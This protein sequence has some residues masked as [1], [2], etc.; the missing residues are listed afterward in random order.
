[1]TPEDCGKSH[2]RPA[3][4]PS[5]ESTLSQ[6][7]AGVQMDLAG[8]TVSH[9]QVLEK[10]GAGGMGV[11]YKARDT[12]LDRIVALKFLPPHLR[13]NEDLKQRLTEEARAASALDHPNIVVIH[14][15]GETAAGD[16]F[17]AMT[18]HEGVTLRERIGDKTAARLTT[19]GALEIA[20]Q[21]ASGLA[22]AHQRGIFHR[23]IKPT[24][25][26]LAKD[27]V[28]RII[29]FGL[30]KSSEATVTMDGSTKGTP[31]YMSPEQASGGAVDSRTDLWSLGAV[32]YEMLAGRPAFPGDMHLQVMHSIVNAPAPRL[33]EVRPDLP[34]SIDLVVARAL[35]K[36]VAKRYP[37][38][39]DMARDL[40]AALASLDP[41]ARKP[42]LLRA[43]YAIPALA[44]VVLLAGAA[45]WLYQRSENRHWAREQIPEIAKL[46]ADHKPVAAFLLAQKAQKYLP[47]DAELSRIADGLTHV[48]S[49]RSSPPGA[50]V[51]I[52]DYL[53]PGDAWFALGSTPLENIKLPSGYLRWRVSK[54]G[55][56]EHN[57]APITEDIHG[58]RKEF[59]FPLEAIAS[60]PPGMVPVPAVDFVDLLWGL[61]LVGPYKLPA[62]YID[63]YE[64]TNRQYQEFVDQGGYQK[65]DYWKEKFLRDG[66]ELS[67]EQAMDLFR[68][69]SGRPGPSTWEAGHF[70]AGHADD[71]VGGVSWYEASAYAEF[72]GKS[73]PVIAQ[74]FRAAP[75]SVAKYIVPQ[76][77]FLLSAVAPGGKYQGLGPWGTYDMGG[78][79]AEWCRNEGGGQFRYILGGGWN[80]SSV[81]YF[82]PGVLPPLNRS[83]NSGFRCVRNTTAL[84]AEA[85]AEIRLQVRDFSKAKP[86]SDEVFRIYKTMWDPL[87]ST[88]R[89]ASL[90]IL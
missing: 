89:H 85:T 11:V 69:A 80:T 79:V 73:L 70:P 14:E 22:Q 81:E 30:A 27:G 82:E 67:W 3:A 64:V 32:L 77:N 31:R 58:P 78:N 16:L 33:R 13:H 51:E 45:M 9:Y 74:W 56:G 76:S 88:C 68:D 83:P 57:G 87:E 8:Q 48:A 36:D 43:A 84:P 61:G 38:G 90:S 52:K 15:I 2:D 24:N 72:A 7:P 49:V 21:I 34:P 25:I 66:K 29:D 71:P 28:A 26:I 55:V 19:S 20:R 47:G 59:N 42:R 46:A 63:R 6:L 86:A 18:Y 40:S 17:I 5:E 53:S 12:R 44:L 10:I 35:E 39:E 65:R 37:S 41:S 50:I 54:A 4:D 60:A 23:D 75:S 1:M 62:Y